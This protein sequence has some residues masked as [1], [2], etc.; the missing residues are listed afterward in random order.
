MSNALSESF[1]NPIVV[2]H[3]GGHYLPANA[4]QKHEYQ[5]F[6]KVQLLQKEDKLR[7]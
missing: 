4:T 1:E 6:F 7:I 2:K 3:P 5:K